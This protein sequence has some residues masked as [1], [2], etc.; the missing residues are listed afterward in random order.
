LARLA[1]L[2]VH[3]SKVGI[4]GFEPIPEEQS[5]KERVARFLAAIGH[6]ID[7]DRVP[8]PEFSRYAARVISH[9]QRRWKR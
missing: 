1:R 8:L 5:F 3:G 4:T 2:E 6:P 7:P 9:W